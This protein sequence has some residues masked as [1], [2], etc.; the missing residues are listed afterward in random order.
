MNTSKAKKNNT[1][2][3]VLN[4]LDK[5][6]LELLFCFTGV[7]MLAGAFT[8]GFQT[9]WFK[10]LMTLVLVV[11]MLK[12]W[13]AFKSVKLTV[14]LLL[15]LA[16][17]SVVGT[18]IKQNET[19]TYYMEKFGSYF[20]NLIYLLNLMDM[21][22]SWWFRLLMAGLC[23]NIIACSIHR[24]STGWKVIFPVKPVLNPGRIK[25]A[26]TP[27]TVELP[28]A[29]DVVADQVTPAVAREY[30]FLQTRQTD[31]GLTLLAEKHRWTRM[32]AYV[33]HL[34]VLLL[35]AGGLIGS[36]FGFEGYVTLPEGAAGET[37]HLRKNN[38]PFP[39]PFV[40]RCDDF[41]V[42]FYKNGMPEKFVSRLT[43]IENGKEVIRKDIIVNDPLRYRGISIYQ[44]GYGQMPADPRPVADLASKTIQLHYTSAESGMMYTRQLTIG[45]SFDLPEGKG[46]FR[47]KAHEP[48]GTFGGQDIGDTLIGEITLPGEA[49]KE[50]QLP[51]RFA[52]FDRMRQGHFVFS[53]ANAHELTAHDPDAEVRYYTGLQ[54]VKDPGV[55]VVYAGFILMIAGCYVSF[56]MS[57]QQVVVELTAAAGQT[58]VLIAAMA[59]K[60]QTGAA[61]K[62][63]RL[64]E[65][66]QKNTAA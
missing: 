8:D 1:N 45:Q 34:S 40:I 36:F 29:L 31:N 20:Y 16:A 64:S 66:L 44:S 38:Q 52:G 14:V 30:A 28:G 47:L 18:L 27:V 12:L 60:N 35:I 9:M 39:L 42:S 46:K 15:A 58:R 59:N 41:E 7:L 62:C 19:S 26:M 57:H 61:L 51:I 21:Y 4:L 63:R 6:S 22:H 3:P 50:I 65:L 43:L 5:L 53:I 54:V 49:P 25:S 11:M 56:F 48:H 37:I 33:V 24:L 17:T 2:N 13:P 32:G 23:I 55:W 10:S